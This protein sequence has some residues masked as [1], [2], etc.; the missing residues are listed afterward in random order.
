MKRIYLFVIACCLISFPVVAQHSNIEFKSHLEFTA[1]HTSNIWGY[2]KG[3][4]EYALVGL[5]GSAGHDVACAIVDVTHPSNPVLLHTVPGPN[6]IWR[7]I[8]TWGDYAYITTEAGGGVTIVD[9]SQL[10][11]SITTK[12]ITEVSAIHALHIDNGYLYLY[13]GD[14]PVS[15]GGIYVLDLTDPWNPVFAGRYNAN[16]VH[17]GIVR[18]NLAFAGEI[19]QGRFSVIDFTDKANPVVITSQK[20]PSQFTHN[21]WLS[22]DNKYLYTTDEKEDAYVAS[23]DV[24]DL[25]N[26]KFLDQY[27]RK[28]ANGAIPHNTYVLND[29][30]VTGF[31]TDFLV[32]SYYTEGVTIVDA[33][34]PDNLVE[35]GNYDTSPLSGGGFNGAWGVYPYLPSGNLLVSD[36]ELG[37]YVLAPQYQRASYLEGKITN[38]A[39]GQPL[40]AADITFPVQGISKTAS[41]IGDYKTGLPL[42]GNVDVT[43]SRPGFTPVTATVTLVAG[44]VTTYNVSLSPV[45]SG[46]SKGTLSNLLV[47]PNPAHDVVYFEN[48]EDKNI[49]V[50]VFNTLGKEL[51]SYRFDQAQ[52]CSVPLNGLA[53]GTYLFQLS[54]QQGAILANKIIQKL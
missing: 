24:S 48:L 8:R 16:Y 49:V 11:A 32:T 7:E 22:S 14:S 1:S 29:Q 51:H 53:Q 25:N 31:N 2:E 45:N 20:T 36:I 42:E 23:Y 10:P 5:T 46:I 54:S 15:L 43:V 39:T 4:K 37:L 52:H 6:S 40:F 21:T 13:G 41:I 17:D 47:Y 38:A 33:H 44:Q 50:K 19:I 28:N 3:G 30:G 12:M 9:L 34:H 27:R 35:V 26:I 18:N